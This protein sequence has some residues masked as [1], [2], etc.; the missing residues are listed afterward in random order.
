VYGR[1]VVMSEGDVEK[2]LRTSVI[3]TCSCV[4]R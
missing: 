4:E 1:Q 2:R 3:P